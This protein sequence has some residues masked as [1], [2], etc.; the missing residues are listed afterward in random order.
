MIL[1]EGKNSEHY[2][3]KNKDIKLP[4]STV[5]CTI[6]KCNI[7]D[8]SQVHRNHTTIATVNTIFVHT[9]KV[10]KVQMTLFWI[11][12]RI[13]IGTPHTNILYSSFRQQF[14]FHVIFFSW[15]FSPM[16][17]TSPPFELI[18]AALQLNCWEKET[19]Q[20]F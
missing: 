4:T 3:N 14:N 8:M 6:E 5:D 12:W 13:P 17:T 19:R 11:S 16:A 18:A 2:K 15:D 1:N 7:C 9:T 10:H 20:F